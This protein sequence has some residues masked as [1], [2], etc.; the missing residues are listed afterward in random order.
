MANR[1]SWRPWAMG[2]VLALALPVA[3]G[4]L[5]AYRDTPLAHFTAQDSKLFR[6]T[7]DDVLEHGADGDTRHWSNAKTGAEGDVTATATFK[8]GEAQCRTVKIRNAAGGLTAS[9]SYNLCKQANGQWKT[10]A[11]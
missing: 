11:S 8:R 6:E 2:A 10:S 4:A 5:R 1:R 9:G 3:S 7:L